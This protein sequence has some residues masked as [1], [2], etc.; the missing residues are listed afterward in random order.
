MV[1]NSFDIALP[2]DRTTPELRVRGLPS[3]FMAFLNRDRPPDLHEQVA[4]YLAIADALEAAV[5]HSA[6]WTS[7]ETSR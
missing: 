7:V 5:S 4:E 6:P 2:S 3:G 1:K